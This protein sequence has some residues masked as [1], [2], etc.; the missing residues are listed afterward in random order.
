VQNLAKAFKTLSVNETPLIRPKALFVKGDI[1]DVKTFNGFSHLYS[2]DT[3]LGAYIEKIAMAWNNSPGTK[4][5][6]SNFTQKDLIY[7]GFD[8]VKCIWHSG[9]KKMTGNCA[10]TFF[11]YKRNGGSSK[12][13]IVS[14]DPI[15]REPIMALNLGQAETYNSRLLPD[16]TAGVKTIAQKPRG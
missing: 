5:Y 10:R 9:S 4:Y 7:A 14:I 8:N 12:G 15:F 13:K 3:C 1:S 2:F 11:I 6:M 16:T